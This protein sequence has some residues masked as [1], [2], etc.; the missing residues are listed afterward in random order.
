[1]LLDSL[2][3][4]KENQPV[5]AALR[6]VLSHTSGHLTLTGSIALQA[7]LVR[8]GLGYSRT[9]GDVDIIINTLDDLSATLINDFIC[10]HVHPLGK[11]GELLL[12]LV[13]PK[14][15]IRFDV[16]QAIGN[17]LSRAQPFTLGSKE[18]FVVSCEDLVA[19]TT[20]LLMK[21]GRGGT[22]A[23]KHAQDFV[24]LISLISSNAV[25]DVWQE[26]RHNLDPF[27]FSEAALC[28]KN[29]IRT[30]SNFLVDPSYNR[31]ATIQCPKCQS[32]NPFKPANPE[33]VFKIL[34]YV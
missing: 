30:H 3:V 2:F 1:M 29:L 5:G 21:L 14:D 26:Y 22:V 25:D 34:G 23:S 19:K 27:T 24:V 28:V 4:T 13:N 6:R 18:I 31:D 20:S 15:A 16:F 17:A 32:A 7:H 8:Q 11:Q 33:Q 9:F 10:P 12:Q